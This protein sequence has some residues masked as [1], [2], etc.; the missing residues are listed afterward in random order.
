MNNENRIRELEKEL[1]E[2]KRKTELTTRLEHI[3]KKVE[4]REQKINDELD[5]LRMEY[6]MLFCDIS[7]M[8]N[9]IMDMITIARVME[10]NKLE[11]LDRMDGM[12]ITNGL[13][14]WYK[15]KPPVNRITI[16]GLSGSYV[17]CELN[18]DL[19]IEIKTHYSWAVK[20]CYEKRVSF[21]RSTEISILKNTIKTMKNF[22]EVFPKFKNAFYEVIDN[23]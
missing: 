9:D 21:N 3:N 17:S 6:S 23:L 12:L 20:D 11:Y 14:W 1:A 13:T 8:T 19:E 5:R 4:E 18:D 15:E 16:N 2:L 10:E 7:T 22:V